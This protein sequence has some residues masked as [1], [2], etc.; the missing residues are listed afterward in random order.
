MAIEQ[1]H[2]DQSKK[3]ADDEAFV[4]EQA[5][6]T[7][8][9]ELLKSK[10]AVK[11]NGLK[12]GEILSIDKL[13]PMKLNDIFSIRTDTEPT[14]NVIEETEGLYKQYIKDIKSRFKEKKAKIIRGHDLAPGV[15][16]I[17]KVYLAIKRRIQPG[18]KMA[19]RH[20]NKG[21]ISEIMPV[22][23]MP[24]DSDGN[25][26]DI[27]LNPLGV[28]SRMNVGQVLET[29]MGSAAK[30]IGKKIDDMLKAN[31]KPNEIKVYL[32]KLYNQNASNKEDIDSFNN[33]QI[34]ELA[35]NLR[36]GL[37]I[38][39]PVFDGAKELSLIHI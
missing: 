19:G 14:N 21:V 34:I 30:G 17:V 32:N 12:K 35:E 8:L 3:D 22:E 39:T 33:N 37:P 36:D 4:V 31:A 25:P 24:Y 7:R 2:L 5:T 23:D 6:K 10:K 26:V 13:D 20:G 11:G 38:A 16:K 1:D 18:D 27:V 29:H 15:I 28:P 9:C